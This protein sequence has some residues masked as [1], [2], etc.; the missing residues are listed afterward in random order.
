[1]DREERFG[2]IL[3]PY[4]EDSQN[5]FVISS[6][7][8][9]WGLRFSYTFFDPSKVCFYQICIAGSAHPAVVPSRH[10]CQTYECGCQQMKKLLDW[11]GE[12]SDAIRWL[13]LQG[14]EAISKVYLLSNCA[15]SE[16]SQENAMDKCS[17]LEERT[18]HLGSA[19]YRM[20]KPVKLSILQMEDSICAA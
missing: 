8:C 16:L 3:A 6:D 10:R 17:M 2:E 7:F 12:I 11:Q 14:V 4:L 13:D 5:F 18:E 15:P 9:H 20:P 1:M 19:Y